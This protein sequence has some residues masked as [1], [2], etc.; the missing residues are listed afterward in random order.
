MTPLAIDDVI[1]LRLN[2]A[3]KEE[4]AALLLRA[5]D[6]IKT[7]GWAQGA[8]HVEDE[9]D[10][11]ALASMD[12]VPGRAL[13]RQ[14]KVGSVCAVGAMSKVLGRSADEMWDSDIWLIRAF[15]TIIG[16]DVTLGT[17]YDEQL[18]DAKITPTANEVLAAM[19]FYLDAKITHWNDTKGREVEEVLIAFEQAAASLKGGEGGADA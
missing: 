18:L 15:G 5:R 1:A 8:Y 2:A 19:N 7:N 11:A 16:E 3:P 6:Y 12:E 13:A 9:A 10:A 4:A 17:L 14:G